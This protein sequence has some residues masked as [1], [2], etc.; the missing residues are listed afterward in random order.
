MQI[1]IN[2][3]PLNYEVDGREGAP[4]VTFVTGIGKDS[5]MWNVQVSELENDFRT[6]RLDWRGHGRSQAIEGDH[7]ADMLM[8]DFFGVWD[9]AGVQKSH[10]VGIGLGGAISIGIGIRHSDRLLSLTP[11][12]CRAV[13][14]PELAAIWPALVKAVRFGGMAAI[15][16]NLSFQV[17]IIMA[18][19]IRQEDAW[20]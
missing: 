14:V 13:M 20:L 7:T 4:W 10:L 12:A 2:G 15:W 5:A 18:S 8:G 6:L 16:P 9:A 1:E 17:C 11:T 3:I 19:Q